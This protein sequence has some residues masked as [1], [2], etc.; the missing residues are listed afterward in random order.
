MDYVFSRPMRSSSILFLFA[1]RFVIAQWSNDPNVNTPISTANGDRQVPAIVSDGARG[2]IITWKDT[3]NTIWPDIYVQRVNQSGIIQWTTNGV[4]VAVGGFRMHEFPRM[5]IDG[6]GG[7]IIA[8]RESPPQPNLNYDIYAQR[9]NTSGVV[10]WP[11]GCIPICALPGHQGPY[12]IVYDGT[13]GAFILWGDGR[14]VGFSDIYIQRVNALGQAQWDSNGVPIFTLYTPVGPSATM[15]NDG[16]GGVI[17][18]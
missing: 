9:I 4:P 16:A 1:F 12:S 8:W 15:T 5:S 3:R 17:I 18:T 10:Q 11:S 14:R 2:A 7:A 13:R 6:T